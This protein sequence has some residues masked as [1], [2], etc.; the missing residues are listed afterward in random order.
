[1]RKNQEV[2]YANADL[3]Q[4]IAMITISWVLSDTIYIRK[5]A[6]NLWD[7]SNTLMTVFIGTMYLDILLIM[8]IVFFDLSRKFV[9]NWIRMV[10]FCLIKLYQLNGG[11]C[12]AYLVD[13][14]STILLLLHWN[15]G[16]DIC[17][18]LSLFIRSLLKRSTLIKPW[19]LIVWY[20]Y[21]AG[22]NWLFEHDIKWSTTS[23][24][25]VP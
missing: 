11:L 15:D 17:W 7:S 4:Y 19:W 18:W 2:S 21:Y 9:Y 1:M 16:F 23:L 3:F 14:T 12:I 6:S 20:I 13:I 25:Y 10:P 22:S 5:G 24:M 8:N